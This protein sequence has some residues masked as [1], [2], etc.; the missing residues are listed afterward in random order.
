MSQKESG[1]VDYFTDSVVMPKQS[2]K[3]I[4][5]G[6]WDE[7]EEDTGGFGWRDITS[8]V[9]VRGGGADNPPWSQ[10]GSGPFYGYKFELS[11]EC[12][13]TF[14]IPHDIVPNSNIHI[15]THWLPDGTSTANVT[16]Q[17]TYVYARGFNQDAFDMATGATVTVQD[18]GPGIA[19]QHMVSECNAITLANLDEPDGLVYVRIKRIANGSPG[20]A[21]NAN[22][23]F[24][25][26]SDVHYQ[27]TNLATIGRTAD[28]GF[29]T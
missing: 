29:Y 13:M 23:I 14:H 7:T 16:W 25:L 28:E 17:Y 5:M 26:T 18:A 27:S 3:G 9:T 6:T 20:G 19:Y 21:D 10:I 22:G 15:H 11:D 2:G 24:M 12:F 8:Q 4:K 1:S